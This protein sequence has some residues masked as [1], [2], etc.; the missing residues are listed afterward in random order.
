VAVLPLAVACNS[1]IGLSDFTKGECAGGRC[2]DGGDLPDQLV[3]GGPDVR[4]DAVADVKGAD[5]VSWAKWPMPNYGEGGATDPPRPPKLVAA[6]DTVTDNVTGLVWHAV[7]T[8]LVGADQ[9]DAECKRLFGPTWRAPKRIEL[10]TLLDYAQPSLFVDSS[11]FPKVKNAQA[12]TTSPVRPLAT[13]P[14]VQAYW[15][16]N[17]GAGSVDALAGDLNAIVLCVAAR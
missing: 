4:L 5:P 16:V 15:T 12:W 10:V 17:F 7:P 11:K 2:G 13:G 6:G 14:A 3:D 9:A 8:G 1:I